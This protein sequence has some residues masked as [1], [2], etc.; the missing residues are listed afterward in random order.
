MIWLHF[1]LSAGLVVGGGFYLARH[2]QEL[3]ERHGLTDIWVGFIFLAAVTSIPELSTALGAVTVAAS[4][5]LAL[6]DVLGSNSFNLFALGVI[7]IFLFRRP[8]SGSLPKKSFLLLIGMIILM[9]GLVLGPALFDREGSLPSPGRISL[10]SWALLFIYLFGSWK[11][12]RDEHPAERINPS[13]EPPVKKSALPR[14]FYPRLLLS[15]ILV[16]AGG[17]W[18]AWSGSKISGLTGWGD[19]FVGALFLALITSLP[20][21]SV[22]LGA[23]KICAPGMALG[24]ILG[25]NVFNLGIIFWADLA[26][27]PGSILANASAPVLIT[28]GLGIVLAGLFALTLKARPAAA[29]REE[30]LLNLIIILVY[31]LGMRWIFRL[32]AGVG[33]WNVLS[34]G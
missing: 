18:L 9:T 5:A 19:G 1:I 17:F 32:S 21:I 20:E 13:V 7:G 30:L 34:P 15:V 24:N 14:Y 22:C 29:G 10:V 12:F 2:G 25:S 33:G 23:V 11:L 4:P 6:S 3:G 31:L 16:V 28:A 8:L 26:Y 27:R